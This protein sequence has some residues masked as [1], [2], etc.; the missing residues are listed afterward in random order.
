M[1]R[2]VLYTS[3]VLLLAS[4]ATGKPQVKYPAP[5]PAPWLKVE[6][7]MGL[8]SA[9]DSIQ[10]ETKTERAFCLIGAIVT[11]TVRITAAEEAEYTR[12]STDTSAFHISCNRA[13]MIGEAHTHPD[14]PNCEFSATDRRSFYSNVKTAVAIVACGNGRLRVAFKGLEDNV[15][16]K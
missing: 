10:A 13:D 15:V 2:R 11:D 9:L 4:C 14:R 5:Y 3:L 8:L 16:L 6:I 7:P 1:F 12:P